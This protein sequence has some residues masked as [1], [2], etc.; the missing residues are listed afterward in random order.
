MCKVRLKQWE[1]RCESEDTESDL[2]RMLVHHQREEEEEEH[3]VM[4]ETL[5]EEFREGN[6]SLFL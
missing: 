4:D 6:P 5:S 3:C 2:Q 1:H